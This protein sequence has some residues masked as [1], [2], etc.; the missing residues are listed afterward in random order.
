MLDVPEEFPVPADLAEP[1][2]E[3]GLNILLF[4]QVGKAHRCEELRANLVARLGVFECLQ[5]EL[6]TL[7][8]NAVEL[9][10]RLAFLSNLLATH[11]LVLCERGQ[12][13]VYRTVAGGK[14]MAERRLEF[15][16]KVV[17]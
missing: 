9:T 8:S 5:Q 6:P 1:V 4:H 15:F 11:K 2:I 17:A 10:V 7:F 13:G 16:F 12:G 14:E 3:D